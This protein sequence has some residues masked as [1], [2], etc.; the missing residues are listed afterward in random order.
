MFNQIS[1]KKLWSEKEEMISIGKSCPSLSWMKKPRP[2]NYS[3]IAAVSSCDF[4]ST[5]PAWFLVQCTYP[6]PALGSVKPCVKRGATRCPPHSVSDIA[7]SSRIRSS[8]QASISHSPQWPSTHLWELH[9]W[10][11]SEGGLE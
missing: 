11:I 5:V 1:G 9:L 4:K 7:D 8:S 6:F 2:Y 3:D 10:G